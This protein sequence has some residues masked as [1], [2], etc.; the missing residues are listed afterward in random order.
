MLS[1][2]SLESGEFSTLDTEGVGLSVTRGSKRRLTRSSAN[3]SKK[4]KVAP[5]V[6]ETATVA[7]SPDA[8]MVLKYMYG[9]GEW[10]RW[11][12]GKNAQLQQPAD[13]RRAGRLKP[14]KTDILQCT[15]DELNFALCLFVKE[16]R[17]PDGD[18]YSPD[19]VF[20]MCIGERWFVVLP[21]VLFCRSYVTGTSCVVSR[22]IR[23]PPP[24]PST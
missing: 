21:F 1:A 16:V 20:Y 10:K 7:E 15:A 19:Y 22:V 9:V 11:V 14:F 2:A 3:N 13:E 23:V 5:A 17:N 6:S 18:E 4:S 24:T 8:N 12:E